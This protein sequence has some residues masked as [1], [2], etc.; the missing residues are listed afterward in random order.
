MKMENDQISDII[1]G[2]DG[3][4]LI[5]MVNNND[6]EAYDNECKSV[7]EAEQTKQFNAKYAEFAPS[8]VTE[9]Q[10]YWKGRVKLGSYTI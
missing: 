3:Y 4:Y 8:Y 5:K 10:S 1:E 6:S 9:V 2:E 7:V